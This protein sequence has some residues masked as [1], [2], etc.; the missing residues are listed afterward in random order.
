MRFLKR[1]V[2]SC[3]LA[4]LVVSQAPAGSR[5]EWQPF[6][7]LP[8][9]VVEGWAMAAS[10]SVVLD[11]GTWRMV[12]TDRRMD[13]DRA[14]L[15]E[16]VSTDGST[17]APAIPTSGPGP[18]PPV[19]DGEPGS[20]DAAVGAAGLSLSGSTLELFFSGRSA[21]G[22]G[23]WEA[24]GLARATD[25]VHFQRTGPD[26]LLERVPG[27][28]DGAEL[29]SPSVV[30][31]QD[32]LWMLF[33]GRCEDPCGGAVPGGRILAAVSSTGASWVRQSTPILEPTDAEAA[34]TDPEIVQGPDGLFYLLFTIERENDPDGIGIA[35]SPHPLGPWERAPEPVFEAGEPGTWDAGGVRAPT[36]V[37]EA[38]AVRLWYEGEPG[39]TGEPA[40]GTARAPWPLMQIETAW[41]REAANPI[42]L[43]FG[44]MDEGE[45]DLAVADPMV[46]WNQE[47]GLFQAWWSTTVIGIYG[48]DGPP[49][50]G[51]R[52]AESSDGIHWTVQRELAF[53]TDLG[54]PSAWDGTNAETPFV[55]RVPGNPPARR[56]LLY[57]SGGNSSTCSTGGAPCYEIGLAFSPDGKAFSRLPAS[58]SP[59]GE[60]GLVLRGEQALPEVTGMALG[61]VADPTLVLEPDGTFR[62]WMSSAAFDPSGNAL[63]FG[64]AHAASADGIHWTP[65]PGNPLATLRRSGE[66]SSGQ[67]PSVLWNPAKQRYEMW[68][69]NDRPGDTARVPAT[70]FQAFGF[71][72]ATSTDGIRWEPEYGDE[73]DFRWDAAYP[74]ERWGLLTGVHVMLH[75]GQYRL[76]Y[77]AWSSTGVPPL[78]T[79]PTQAGS[80]PTVT[81]LNLALRPAGTRSPRRPAGRSHGS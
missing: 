65:T 22:E 70:M 60:A 36:A 62:M 73:P 69:T 2:A 48:P 34:L 41:T 77:A 24:I 18:E 47:R 14:V 79:A 32:K 61:I 37:A 46:L 44:L 38:T 3:F 72:H 1:T 12:F 53:A 31:W 21:N 57:Y 27:W 15:S 81:A 19:L 11:N 68:F 54:D 59:Y 56:Y 80:V 29:A 49:V 42:A 39:G 45:T 4:V 66:L 26:P 64:I 8:G 16:F 76:Y 17:W 55:V 28:F 33:T 40:V 6:D 43:P 74:G 63:A 5:V 9:P 25:G 51:I 75:D 52:Y 58:E 10:P 50:N 23:P 35:R 67:Q 71:W 20:W 30:R 13:P 7:R 78:F